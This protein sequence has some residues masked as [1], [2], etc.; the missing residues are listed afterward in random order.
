MANLTHQPPSTPRQAFASANSGRCTGGRGQPPAWAE[1][2]WAVPDGATHFGALGICKRLSGTARPTVGNEV[3][4]RQEPH[5]RWRCQNWRGSY[6]ST[7]IMHDDIQKASKFEQNSTTGCCAAIVGFS[8][9]IHPEC[10]P[11]ARN[12]ARFDDQMPSRPRR[13]YMITGL[14][15]SRM[16]STELVGRGAVQRIPWRMHRAAR[17]VLTSFSRHEFRKR[18]TPLPARS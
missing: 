9:S 8:V 7:I 1:V 17:I 6:P 3:G 14:P 11:D 13:Y 10:H 5:G 12:L 16:P 15:D 2:G 4:S 18:R